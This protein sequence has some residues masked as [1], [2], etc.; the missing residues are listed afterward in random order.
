MEFE[1]TATGRSY[2]DD[3]HALQVPVA[4]VTPLRQLV[5]QAFRCFPVDLD[6]V[7]SVAGA[8]TETGFSFE[9]TRTGTQLRVDEPVPEMPAHELERNLQYQAEEESRR[10]AAAQLLAERGEI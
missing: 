10:L 2:A 3:V 7:Y 5:A 1:F 9:I 4:D 8:Q 6:A